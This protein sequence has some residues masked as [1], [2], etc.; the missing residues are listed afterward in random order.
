MPD[1]H[2]PEGD[3]HPSTSTAPGTT[4]A[5]AELYLAA[6]QY[7]LFLLNTGYGYWCWKRTM[8]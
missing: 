6:A 3:H 5:L 1:R 7:V 2:R 8:R 4:S